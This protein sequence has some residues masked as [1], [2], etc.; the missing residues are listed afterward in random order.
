[1]RSLWCTK[2]PAILGPYAPLFSAAQHLSVYVANTSPCRKLLY[3]KNQRVF[4]IQETKDHTGEW[5]PIESQGPDFCGNGQWVLKLRPGQMGVFLMAKYR[6]KYQT[7]GYRM[8][9][10]ATYRPRIRAK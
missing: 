6:G 2:S 10:A 3:G 7:F 9:I 4:A 5:R 8:G 1:M